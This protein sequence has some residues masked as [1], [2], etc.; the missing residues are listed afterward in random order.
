ME[1]I[2][3]KDVQLVS[4]MCT[5]CL[6]LDDQLIRKFMQEGECPPCLE[7][8]LDAVP[9]CGKMWVELQLC[10]SIKEWT[11]RTEIDCTCYLDKLRNC[12]A[13][14]KEAAKVIKVPE[15]L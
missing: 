7:K 8:S 11:R 13:S 5:K 3:T 14:N 2:S 15:H 4:H 12:V 6:P 1:R 10:R 9:P